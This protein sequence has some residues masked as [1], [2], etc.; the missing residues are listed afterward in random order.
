MSNI[1]EEELWSTQKIYSGV[2]DFGILLVE[3]VGLKY[4]K[5]LISQGKLPNLFLR[6]SWIEKF[7]GKNMDASD[8]VQEI[9]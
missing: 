5:L 8:M 9:W 2:P 3:E 7:G 6:A 4:Q 1:R